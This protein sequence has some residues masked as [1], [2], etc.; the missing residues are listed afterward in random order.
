MRAANPIRW[1]RVVELSAA[2]LLA[3]ALR[4]TRME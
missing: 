2:A 3:A 1:T 4:G